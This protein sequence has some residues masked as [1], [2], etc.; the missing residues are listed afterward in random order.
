MACLSG[1]KCDTPTGARHATGSR[2]ESKSRNER[3]LT[4][5]CVVKGWL[6]RRA[7]ERFQLAVNTAKRWP[8]RY[9]RHGAVVLLRMPSHVPGPE[10]LWAN[11]SKAHRTG[12]TW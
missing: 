12:L 5:V 11:A 8:D 2:Q 3:P 6:L 7:A 4:E 10:S 9:R 1:W